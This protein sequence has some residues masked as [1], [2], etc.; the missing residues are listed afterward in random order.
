MTGI[1]HP[2]LALI[3][4]VFLSA[5]PACS[6]S[7]TAPGFAYTGIWS[8]F[9]KDYYMTDLGVPLGSAISL[10]VGKDGIGFGTG[11]L[12]RV[13]SNGTLV[14]RLSM[15][16]TVY[17]DG[18]II[19]QGEWSFSF[20]GMGMSGEGEVIG[21]LDAKNNIGSGALRTL[22]GDMLLQFPWTVERE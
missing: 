13:Y 16:F 8:G 15:T 12:E 9:W 17:P 2:I 7:P 11:E 5:M 22:V 4:L 10:N 19:G 21:Q 1:R 3:L 6:S 14:D 20:P 18:S